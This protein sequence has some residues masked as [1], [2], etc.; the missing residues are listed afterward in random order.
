MTP[1][2]DGTRHRCHPI[3]LFYNEYM[4]LVFHHSQV[5]FAI[6]KQNGQG[7]RFFSKAPDRVTPAEKQFS[8]SL[9][10]GLWLRLLAD[11]GLCPAQCPIYTDLVHISWV[12]REAQQ[13]YRY[14]ARYRRE[15]I[16]PITGP[17]YPERPRPRARRRS[18]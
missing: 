16:D 4:N 8:Y 14:E 11:Q 13:R 17:V 2:F 18:G 6:P 3:K 1:G 9:D 12:D 7:Y 10:P 5:P 15:L